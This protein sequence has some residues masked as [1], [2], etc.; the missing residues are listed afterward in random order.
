MSVP[1]HRYNVTQVDNTL[2]IQVPSNYSVCRSFV[3]LY[4]LF[5]STS[6]Y[7]LNQFSSLSLPFFFITQA[8]LVPLFLI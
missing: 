3:S 7:D 1:E 4:L 2:N 6:F 5:F 8:R